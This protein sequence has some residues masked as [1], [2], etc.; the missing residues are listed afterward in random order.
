MKKILIILALIAT[1]VGASAQ[2]SKHEVS[3]GLGFGTAGQ[4]IDVFGDIASAFSGC[5]SHVKGFSG[6]VNLDY[7]YHTSSKCLQGMTVSYNR[8]AKDQYKKSEP[9][10]LYGTSTDYYFAIMPTVKFNWV[11]KEHFA[12]Y[13]RASAG[14]YLVKIEDRVSK[15]ASKNDNEVDPG[16]AFQFSPV[17]LE[18]GGSVRGFVE[19]G[20]GATGIVNGGVRYRF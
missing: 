4:I 19:L 1:C 6:S 5:T 11:N 13:S 20:F 2:D 7:G 3:L 8:V 17:G 10:E 14:L 12:F 16:F 9:N 18:A 15:D